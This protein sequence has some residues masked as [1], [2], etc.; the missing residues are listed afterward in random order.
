MM[1]PE[2]LTS[3]RHARYKFYAYLDDRDQVKAK[4]NGQGIPAT[5]GSCPEIYLEKAFHGLWP[6][7]KR[8]PNAKELGETSLCLQVHP[9]LEREHVEAVGFAD[10][11]VSVI[12]HGSMG[13][14]CLHSDARGLGRQGA[15][16]GRAR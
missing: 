5:V 10:P 14:M 15:G 1:E 12:G 8:L 13:G 11:R 9:T 4:R 7:S 2:V 16:A 3:L 6:K